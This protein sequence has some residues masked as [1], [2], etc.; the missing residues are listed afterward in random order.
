MCSLRVCT[1]DC[2]SR[3]SG[4]GSQSR[5][6]PATLRHSVTAP[7]RQSLLSQPPAR[8]RHNIR[9]QLWV[10][11]FLLECDNSTLKPRI[12]NKKQ[13]KCISTKVLL[14]AQWCAGRGWW[15]CWRSGGRWPRC[16]SWGAPRPGWSGRG[17][18][19]TSTASQTRPTSGATGM[20]YCL[21]G[22]SCAL[23][24]YFLIAEHILLVIIYHAR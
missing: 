23:T 24:Y 8:N 12:R 21:S 11:Q 5:L 6:R 20:C 10:K 16:R 1:S 3:H 19:S 15:R 17:T 22:P 14:A 4:D 2:W 18:R 7:A 9:P 13:S